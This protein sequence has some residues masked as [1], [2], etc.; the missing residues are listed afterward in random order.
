MSWDAKARVFDRSLV[1]QSCRS[2]RRQVLD[3]RGHVI[4]NGYK[5]ADGYL[6]TKVLNRE[7][8]SRDVFRLEA[9]TRWLERTN[10][11]KAG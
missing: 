7:G 11:T 3:R 4:R 6:A 8:L 2:V 1:C 5:Y 10:E 9:L